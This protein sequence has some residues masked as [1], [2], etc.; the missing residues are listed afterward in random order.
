M[1]VVFIGVGSNLGNRLVNINK[2]VV[3]MEK[4]GVIVIDKI[5]SLIE[6]EPQDAAGPKY[7]NCVLKIQTDLSPKDLLKV[8]HSIEKKLGRER[9]FRNAP[10]TIDL[11]I[12][13]Y[14]DI[15]MKSAALTIPHPKMLER[16]FVI[17]PLL[18]IEPGISRLLGSLN[19]N[20]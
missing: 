2:A 18:E 15:R 6:T 16:D 13:L 3:Y 5:S 12:L 11:D 19:C 14:D 7:L 10:R 4:T 1:A 9:T 20:N 8:L 17:K